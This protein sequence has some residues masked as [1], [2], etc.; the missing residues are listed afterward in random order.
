[1]TQSSLQGQ[2]LQY[3]YWC[4]LSNRFN[5]V[6]LSTSTTASSVPGTRLSWARRRSDK[7]TLCSPRKRQASIDSAL[8]TIWALLPRSLLILKS[9]YG[10]PLPSLLFAI[11]MKWPSQNTG[12][13]FR[14]TATMPLLIKVIAAY[15][16][17]PCIYEHHRSRMKPVRSFPANKALLPNRPL[18]SKSP[19][20]KFQ[21]NSRPS[22]A[23]KSTSVHAR[24]AI[25]A[26][27][28]AL[29]RA[30]SILASWRVGW[31]FVWL[32]CRFLS[33]GS[34]SRGRGKVGYPIPRG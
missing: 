15:S 25:S 31:W 20:T 7:G 30:S 10:L 11:P 34:F 5:L 23:C 3:C 28:R 26:L 18:P 29:S 9:R 6:A 16:L 17:L 21:A 33:S 12:V 14:D 22:T 4:I 24:T 19:S 2:N 27:S 8:I 1:M 13:M 32:V